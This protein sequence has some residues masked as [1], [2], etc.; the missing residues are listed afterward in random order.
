MR[1]RTLVLIGA[2][3]ALVA[4]PRPAAAQ[5]WVPDKG[6][7][8]VSFLYQD[9]FVRNHLT[10]DGVFQDNGHIWSNNLMMDVSYGVTDRLAVTLAA[11]FIR[12]RYSGARP[13]PTSQDDGTAH[14][15]F[16][17]IRFGARYN[18]FDGPVTITPF[19]GTSV[20]SHSYEYFAHAAYGTRVRDLEVGTYVAHAL[21][22]GLPHAFVQA[23]YAFGFPQEIAGVRRH[24]ST[25]DLEFGYF[26]TPSLRV[27]TMGAG[28]KTLG[29]V[30]LPAAGWGALPANL[31]EHHDRVARVDIL[32]VGGGAQY[33]ITQSVDIFGSFMR[34]IAGRNGHALARGLTVGASWSFGKPRL[35][36]LVAD[37]RS[38]TS[39][40]QSL[41]RCLCQK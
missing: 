8:S 9:L 21:T 32:D 18:L 26:I 14:S 37:A 28:Q 15:G 6:E 41:I 5:A 24:R 38:A 4:G 19:I 27:F 30:D 40:K 25:L 7:G 23:R 20:P 34:T 22:A 2:L 16:Q 3:A 36:S 35:S 10:A 33:S 39:T 13:H 31:R 29:G 1:R 17:D 12:T 11:P